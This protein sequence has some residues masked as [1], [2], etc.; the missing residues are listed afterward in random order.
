MMFACEI[1]RPGKKLFTDTLATMLRRDDETSDPADRRAAWKIRDEFGT[2]QADDFAC[3]LCKEKTAR[4]AAER[5]TQAMAHVRLLRR[6]A[7][8]G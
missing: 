2:N 4:V 1:G 8:F 5:V 7:E 3:R 6:I